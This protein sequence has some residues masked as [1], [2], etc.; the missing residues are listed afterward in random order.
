M[1]A[2]GGFNIV[3]LGHPHSNVSVL[4]PCLLLCVYRS[5]E[6]ASSPGLFVGSLGVL[7]LIIFGGHP[8]TILHVL[9]AGF[10]LAVFLL[11]SGLKSSNSGKSCRYSALRFGG[12]W[13]LT[14]GTAALITAVQWVP[15]LRYVHRW[16]PERTCRGVPTQ[17]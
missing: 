7:S 10:T 2:F 13:I 5:F 8:A 16:C 15:F 4:L 14:G 6:R 1:F 12:F 9:F 11:F 3:W 17:F